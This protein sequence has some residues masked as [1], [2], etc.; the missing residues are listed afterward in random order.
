M[1]RA[2]DTFTDQHAATKE[3][4][5]IFRPHYRLYAGAFV[6]VV[7][8]HFLA[9]DPEEFTERS[10]LDFSRQVYASMDDYINILP[11]K[12]GRMYP[13][14]KEQNWLFHYRSRQGTEKSLG[15]VVRRALYLEESHTAFRLFEE[16]YPL[17]GH[18]YRSFWPE[19]K[20]FALQQFH[21]LSSS[22]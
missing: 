18:L 16:N 15:G 20:L 1:H 3:A 17:L 14:M 9:S 2:I 6:D 8:D 19:L 21:L 22:E 4:K 13:Y 12:F 7:Y 10:L 11:E 5:E